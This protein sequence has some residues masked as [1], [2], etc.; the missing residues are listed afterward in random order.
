MMIFVYDNQGIIIAGRVQCGTSATA[1]YYCDFLQKLC[2]KMHKTRAQLLKA[3]PFILHDNARPHIGH[4][5]A[6]KLR[7]YS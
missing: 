2:R 7:V 3:G 1:V 6:E 5:V 4:V